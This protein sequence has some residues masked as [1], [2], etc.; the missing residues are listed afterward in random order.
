MTIATINHARFSSFLDSLKAKDEEKKRKAAQHRKAAAGPCK[1]QSRYV[2]DGGWGHS[3]LDQESY[4]GH[5]AY[6]ERR[7]ASQVVAQYDAART[8]RARQAIAELARADAR[9]QPDFLSEEVLTLFEEWP[10]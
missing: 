3:R 10:A 7:K 4:V 9:K 6:R 2:T 1:I 5:W 8:E